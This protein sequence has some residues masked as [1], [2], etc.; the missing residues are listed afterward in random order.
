R[1]II[2]YSLED[3]LIKDMFKNHT[4]L[5]NFEDLISTNKAYN[6]A[7]VGDSLLAIGLIY[8]I[9][10]LSN[11]PNEN[12]LNLYLI[13]KDATKFLDRVKKQF[14]NIER[15]GH[16]NLIAYELDSNSL[17]FYKDMIWKKENLTNI[18]IVDDDE[19]KNLD[20]AINLQDT[21]YPLESAKDK[22]K[23]KIIFAI[24]NDLGISQK[25]D[26]NQG[27]FRSFYTFANLKKVINSKNIIDEE[28]DLIA[29]LI[30]FSYLGEKEI[31][32]EKLNQKWLEL[33]FFKRDS[34]RAQALHID[35]KLLALGLK[36][37]KSSKPLKELLTINQKIFKETIK[38]EEKDKEFPKEFNTLL[39]KLARAEH[40]RWSAFHYL[41]GWDYCKSRDDKAK[42]HN[43]LLPFSRFT[44][45]EQKE[46]YRYDIDSIQNIP[47]Y[48]AHAG[49]E[50]KREE[51]S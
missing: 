45:K 16:L 36:K 41:N 7:I 32:K 35:I 25:I 34:N 39:S 24:Y 33:D 48:L 40:N 20:I 13:N 4:I 27:V 15:I 46:T 22:L 10:I 18:F 50:I 8:H 47:I 44:T 11:L 23:T 2:I 9:A 12:R 51:G 19:S 37:Q 31:D 42:R 1:D 30:H 5:G 43:C 17:S 14:S 29:K 3:I 38:I 28:L 6:I 26:K 21:T 49:Y